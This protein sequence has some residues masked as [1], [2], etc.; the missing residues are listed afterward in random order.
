VLSRGLDG[1]NDTQCRVDIPIRNCSL[2]DEPIVK[3]G[4]LVAE[5]MKAPSLVASA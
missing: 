4:D 5:E 1:A 2:Y 3:D